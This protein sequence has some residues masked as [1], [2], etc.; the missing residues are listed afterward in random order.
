MPMQA[1]PLLKDAI[2]LNYG[3]QGA[4]VVSENHA[5][6]DA[7]LSSVV[8]IDMPEQWATA[9]AGNWSVAERQHLGY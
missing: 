3:K 8:K 2:A 5:A 9:D 1:I 6:V 4:L 7:A